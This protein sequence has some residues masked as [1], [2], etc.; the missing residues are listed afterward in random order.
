EAGNDALDERMPAE[1]EMDIELCQ[2]RHVG[3]QLFDIEADGAMRATPGGR[4]QD[5]L[6]AWRDTESLPDLVLAAIRRCY[7]QVDSRV[8]G[9]GDHPGIDA[10]DLVPLGNDVRR[11]RIRADDMRGVQQVTREGLVLEETATHVAAQ[12]LEWRPV[13][14]VHVL[15]AGAANEP[16]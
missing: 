16:R 11:V 2:L 3:L 15:L 4:V 8:A 6:G 7:R 12:R 9:F 13:P 14:R 1:Q 10:L 5:H